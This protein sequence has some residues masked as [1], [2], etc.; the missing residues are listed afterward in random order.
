MG[1]AIS[2]RLHIARLY[3]IPGQQ[4]RFIRS[5]TL[6]RFFVKMRLALKSLPF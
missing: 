3:L 1:D 2:T 6:P 5:L 4:K